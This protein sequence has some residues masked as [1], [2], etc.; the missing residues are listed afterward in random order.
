VNPRRR[1]KLS[2]AFTLIELLVVI[3]IMAILAAIAVPAIKNIGKGH[4]TQSA[5]RQ[6]LDDIARARQL[7]IAN[8]TTVYMVFVPMNFWNNNSYN[9]NQNAWSALTTGP[10]GNVELEK[11]RPLLDKQIAAYTFITLRSVGDQPGRNTVQYL[12]P[13]RF[14]PESTYIIPEKFFAPNVSDPVNVIAGQQIY[15]FGITN[16]F[17]FP[18]EES[19]FNVA[20]GP[21]FWLPFI[22]FNYLGQLELGRDELIPLA[23]GN[24]SYARD[25]NKLPNFGSVATATESPVGNSTNAYTMIRIDWVTGRARIE[26]PQIQ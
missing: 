8:H 15:K 23:R 11:A 18:S 25:A 1:Q 9:G 5:S 13:W 22:S 2:T 10:T 4:A 17:P 3:S 20:S 12:S 16:V 26:Q 7:A 6:L 24:V 14:L 19:P 21:A